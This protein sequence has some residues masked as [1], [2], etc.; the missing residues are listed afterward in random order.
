M[1]LWVK[2]CANTSLAD[3]Q[4]AADAGADAVGFVFAPS[5]RRV[6]PESV[7]A[8]TPRLPASIGKIGVFVGADF[9][10][11]AGTIELAGL[12]G[13]Q[14]QSGGQNSP[15]DLAPR[16]RDKF[17]PGLS[18]LRVI[19][20]GDDAA[21]QLQAAKA[22][23]CINAVLVDSRTASAVGGT[24]VAFDWQAARATIFVADGQLQLIAA[25]GLTPGN[26]SQAIS[27]LRPWGVDVATGVESSP[28]RKDP[29][30]VREFVTN[31]RTVASRE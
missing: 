30:K 7:A 20:F 13:V 5:P 12:T 21:R 14:L 28:G 4:L 3:A 11:I 9:A 10:T 22:D 6:T 27:T 19:H 18:I 8:I 29:Q 15:G 25:G 2:I 23:P 17:G 26:V 16:L 1:S 24:G 31:A